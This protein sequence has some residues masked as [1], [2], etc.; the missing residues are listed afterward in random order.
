MQ[1]NFI[2]LNGVVF[3]NG[4]TLSVSDKSESID[5]HSH[6]DQQQN[7]ITHSMVV[8]EVPMN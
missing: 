2:R 1:S 4:A 6:T 7:K 5:E 8:P 3:S